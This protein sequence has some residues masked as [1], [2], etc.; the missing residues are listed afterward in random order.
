MLGLCL[1]LLRI[2]S[3]SGQTNH[4]FADPGLASIQSRRLPICVSECKPGRAK[5]DASLNYRM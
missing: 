4:D 3:V 1:F 5:D 2:K